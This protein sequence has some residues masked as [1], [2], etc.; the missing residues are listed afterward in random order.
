M[1]RRRSPDFFFTKKQGA[2][3]GE[4]LLRINLFLRF[5]AIQAFMA[6]AGAGRPSAKSRDIGLGSRTVGIEWRRV[7]FASIKL[8]SAPESTKT[9]AGYTS[10]PLWIF[11][12]NISLN[13]VE[14]NGLTVNKFSILFIDLKE[15]P[16]TRL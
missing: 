5:L 4:A 7:K 10:E 9:F 2:P 16:M 14:R 1:H 13:G 11:A 12:D 6:A 8:P 3:N 15:N